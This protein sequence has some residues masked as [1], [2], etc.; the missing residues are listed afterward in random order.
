MI[1]FPAIDLKGGKCVRLLKGKF[2]SATVYNDDPAGQARLFQHA[3]CE[4]IHIVDLD[5]A[6]AGR[7]L[8]LE[9]VSAIVAAV[10]IPLQLGGGIREMETIEFWLDRGITRVI[11]GT[12]AVEDP[13]LVAT[14][15]KAFPGHVAVGIDARNGFASLRGWLSDS[16][17]S[18][19]EVAARFEDSG[20]AALI[21]TDIDR[22]GTKSGVNVAA[23]AELARSVSVPVI[24]S[25]GIAAIN[26]LLAL[27]NCGAPIHGAVAGRA[28]YDGSI[29]IREA[30]SRLAGRK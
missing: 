23:T 20:V 12:S 9:S 29:N 5:G 10:D 8:N 21:Y 11:L 26:D 16:D 24:A 15:A 4:W 7:P 6:A 14:A 2:S 30:L 3:G 17:M 28:I 18:A 27:Q 13:E 25:G 1:L 22:D 19:K